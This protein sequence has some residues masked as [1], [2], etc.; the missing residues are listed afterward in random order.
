VNHTILSLT[1]AVHSLGG[2]S[3]SS[4]A[5]CEAAAAACAEVQTTPPARLSSDEA[6][7]NSPDHKPAQTRMDTSLDTLGPFIFKLR[8]RQTDKQTDEAEYPTNANV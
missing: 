2:I 1:E 6:E 3:A 5:D 4:A 7:G 8:C